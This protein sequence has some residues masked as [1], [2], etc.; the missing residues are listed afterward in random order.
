MSFSQGQEEAIIA[1]HFAGRKGRFLD[2]GANDGETFSN[3]RALAISGWGGTLVEP[4]PGAFERLS[5]L[6]AGRDDIRL[7]EA[8]ITSVDGPCMMHMASDSLVSSLDARAMNTWERHGFTWVEQE[9]R[10]ITVATLIS[11]AHGPYHLI[12]ID[13]EGHDMEILRQMD[14]RAMGCEM[15]VIEHGEAWNQIDA[16]CKRSGYKRIQ[17][18]GINSIYVG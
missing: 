17:R 18:D 10:G 12:S 13:A 7:V 2:I 9:V 5:G 16:Y 14:L 3:T 8:A 15:L 4:N 1:A 11:D 6:Y